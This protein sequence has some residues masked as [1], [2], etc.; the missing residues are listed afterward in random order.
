MR[1]VFR[2]VFDAGWIVFA[3]LALLLGCLWIVDLIISIVR[4]WVQ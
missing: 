2:D 4:G 3:S 1:G